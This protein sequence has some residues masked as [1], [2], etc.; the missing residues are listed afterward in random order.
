MLATASILALLVTTLPATP[1]L[2]AAALYTYRG[3]GKVGDEFEVYGIGFN[4][5]DDYDIY[6][7]RERA[8]VGDYIDDDVTNYE[9]LGM[10]SVSN[11]TDFEGYYFDV[12]VQLTDGNS[13]EKVHG[14]SYWVYATYADNDRIRAR[15]EF[16]VEAVAAITL[17]LSEGTVGTEVQ[18]TGEEFALSESLTVK[19]NSTNAQT[20]STD[21]SGGFTVTFTVPE[22]P[23]GTHT[24]AA[25]DASSNSATAT[26]TT[27]QS[28][29][30]SPTSGAAGDTITV[31]GT[32]FAASKSVTIS[33]DDTEATTIETNSVGSFSDATFAALA[34][35]AG[36]YDIEVTDADDNSDSAEFTLGAAVL[37]LS[38]STGYV[39]SEVT[40]S[41]TGFQAVQQITITFDNDTIATIASDTNGSFTTSFDI[42]VLA[43]DS[44]AVTA[45]DGTNTA[46]A[47]F[48]ISTSASISPQTSTAAPGHVGSELII[49]GIGFIA[50][51]AINV[52]YD[53]SQMATATVAT[54][55]TFSATFTV[56]AGS[57]GE[58][59][60]T[61]TDGVN[62]KQFTFIME[63]TPPDPPPPL[64]PEMDIKAEAETYF[65]WEDV[66][67]PSGVT[68]TLQIATAEDFATDSI[69]LE[70]TGL[71]ESEYTITK[72]ERLKSVSEK[73]PYYWHV[74]TV[75]GTLSESQWSGTGAFRVGFSFGLS[76]PLIYTLL[77][78]SALFL[79]V[80]GFWLG[81]KTAYY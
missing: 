67:D 75:D 30:V 74:K 45:S 51:N 27:K 46:E 78:F 50:G 63:S 29:T 21:S 10:I 80:F 20:A 23:Q 44:Y 6:F 41:G 71:T 66:T 15:V 49:S 33:F 68:Y 73:E 5:G 52:T 40:V 36:S 2:A 35:G 48:S 26:F 58:H 81:R 47:D 1:A 57:G 7:S 79:G 3:D 17:N 37:S 65:D 55:G 70:K 62:T 60:I 76:Q 12:P 32:G 19:F 25:E 4:A 14:G 42:P 8:T 24:I 13:T 18:V 9:R 69:V 39:G 53:E 28:I 34:R 64:Q 16:T 56:P 72:E 43:A 38:P 77:I 11:E 54:D 22:S 61:A 59:N 31:S